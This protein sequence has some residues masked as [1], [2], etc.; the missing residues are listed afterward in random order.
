[1]LGLLVMRLR[2]R[3]YRDCV[4]LCVCVWGGGGGGVATNEL[5]KQ[6]CSKGQDF[7]IST[8]WKGCSPTIPIKL[9]YQYFST[10]VSTSWRIGALLFLKIKKNTT[11]LNNTGGEVG[12][13]HSCMVYNTT[14]YLRVFSESLKTGTYHKIVF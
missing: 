4:C 8:V 5:K 14:T 11:D 3:N 10:L 9:L 6:S 12:L 7:E 2:E 13:I 1:M